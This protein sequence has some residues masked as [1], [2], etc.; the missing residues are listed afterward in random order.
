MGEIHGPPPAAGCE[1]ALRNR[2]AGQAAPKRILWNEVIATLLNHRAVRAYLPRP[3]PEVTL[4]TLLAAA[5]S[6]SSSSNLHLWSVVAVT[7][8]DIKQRLAEL[9]LDQRHIKEAPLLLLWVADLARLTSLGER[10][11]RATEGLD[12]LES[13]VTA[14]IDTGLA[15][16][17]ACVAA[18]SLGLG[19]CY[20]GAMRN[21]PEEVAELVGLPPTTMVLFGLVV[22]W[23]DPARPASIKPRP[24]QETLLHHNRYN[25]AREAAC[26]DDYDQAM[27]EFQKSQGQ[28][29]VGWKKAV[30]SRVANAAALT[31]RH[32]LGEALRNLRFRL[33]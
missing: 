24:V 23:P 25:N 13:F 29:V 20:I 32:R 7:D 22:G 31:G 17:N 18:E 26:V 5:Q 10:E 8:P 33:L 6:A 28:E 1:G 3:L 2:Y 19:T 16:Q 9:A 15:A 27:R 14:A 11:A 4:E 21:H 12:Y 30:L